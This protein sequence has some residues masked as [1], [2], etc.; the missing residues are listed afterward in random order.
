VRRYIGGLPSSIEW[1]TAVPQTEEERRK[2]FE[3]QRQTVKMLVREVL[4]DKDRNLCV[5]F[6]L[7]ILTLFQQ[8]D[9]TEQVQRVGICTRIRSCHP[10]P[11]HGAC[12]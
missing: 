3:T 6:Y 12:G 10:L 5:V 9:V 1:L 7:D 8:D 4:I 11:L 2:Q